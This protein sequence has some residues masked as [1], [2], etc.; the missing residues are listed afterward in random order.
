MNPNA[1]TGTLNTQPLMLETLERS[2][3]SL[4]WII[5]H[6]YI[7]LEF[8]NQTTPCDIIEMKTALIIQMRVIGALILREI[9]TR[10]GHSKIGFAWALLEPITHIAVLSMIFISIGRTPP[11]GNSMIPFFATGILPF[12]LFRNLSDSVTSAL[13]ANRALLTYPIVKEVDTLF[14]RAM[15]ELATSVLVMMIVY[16]LLFCFGIGPLPARLSAMAGAMLSLALLG[17]GVGT[18]NSVILQRMPSWKNVYNLLTRPLFFI[19]GVFFTIDTLPAKVKD[20]LLWNPILHGVEWMRYG[21]YVNFRGTSFDANY[22]MAW[23]LGAT[24]LGLVVERVHRNW[25]LLSR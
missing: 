19:S 14:A 23:G 13:D 10:Y 8:D 20:I 16:S 1:H 25:Y 11:V 21:Y 3:H 22:I 9:R 12:L 5:P 18:I 2:A 4:D 7:R 15:L 17:F 24:V 6:R